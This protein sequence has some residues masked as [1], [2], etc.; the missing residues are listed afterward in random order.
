M[1]ERYIKRLLDIIISLCG[2]ILLSPVYLILVILVRKKLG[3]PVLFTQ[4]RPGKDEKIFKLYKFRSM[5]DARDEKGN[6]LPDEKRLPPFGKK[7]RSTSLDELPELFNILKGEMSVIGPRPLLVKYLP[8]YND[9]QKHRHD[10]RPGLTGLAQINGRNAITWEKKFEYDVEYVDKIS[11]GLD[12]KIFFSTVRA[13]LKREG[14][15]SETDATM[16]AFKGTP[17]KEEKEV[18]A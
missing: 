8:L 1:Y 18:K 10:V 17:L 14:I 5:T 3:S 9:V 12:L 7:L 6:L 16:E 4:E 15:S 13:V 2:I 11:F